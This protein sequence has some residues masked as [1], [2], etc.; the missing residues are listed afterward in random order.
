MGG[1]D[2]IRGSDCIGDRD[3]M[4]GSNWIRGSDLIRGSEF[5]YH[6]GVFKYL[7]FCLHLSLSL[8]G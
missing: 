4:G 6:Q 7:R 8:N 2:W 5:L 1:S 3:W